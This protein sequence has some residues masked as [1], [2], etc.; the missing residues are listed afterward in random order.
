MTPAEALAFVKTQGVALEAG[1]GP[2][3]S[4]AEAVA[5]GRIHG[6]WWVHPQGRQI[7]AVTRAVRD[8][9]DVLVCRLVGGKLTDWLRKRSNSERNKPLVC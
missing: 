7:F 3:A 5:G 9:P 8:C 1:T 4:L 6:S 2:V